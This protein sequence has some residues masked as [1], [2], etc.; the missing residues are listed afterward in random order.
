MSNLWQI[1][2]SFDSFSFAAKNCV[3][4]FDR[5]YSSRKK[6]ISRPLFTLTGLLFEIPF[7]CYSRI[8]DKEPGDIAVSV[9]I[10]IALGLVGGHR[11]SLNAIIDNCA[12]LKVKSLMRPKEYSYMYDLACYFITLLMWPCKENKVSLC[13]LQLNLGQYLCILKQ[14]YLQ[15]PCLQFLNNEFLYLGI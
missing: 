14:L 7:R 12:L 11:D 9:C 10:N 5:P 8:E 13:A 4:G 6:A 3:V 1:S 2:G 15:V